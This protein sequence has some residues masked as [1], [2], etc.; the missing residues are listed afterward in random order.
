MHTS[1]LFSYIH[2][3]TSNTNYRRV[4]PFNIT[5][6]RRAHKART[7]WYRRPIH[8]IYRHQINIGRSCHKYHF[9]RDKHVYTA[10]NVIFVATSIVL[11]RQ[12][13][14]KT[15]VATKMILVAVPAND[16]LEVDYRN[17]QTNPERPSVEKLK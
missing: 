10:T 8:L 12:T 13:R 5:P 17:T 1:K 6:V 7:C 2:T 14:D 4:S 9:C 11:S 15:F 3:Q 16:R